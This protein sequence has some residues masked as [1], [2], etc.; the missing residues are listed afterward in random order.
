MGS[1]LFHREDN[2]A[3]DNSIDDIAARPGVFGGV[4]INIAWSQIEPSPGRFTTDVI[5]RALDTVRSYNRAHPTA[6]LGV[7]LR[8][9]PGRNAPA[10]VNA[11]GGPPIGVRRTIPGQPT[12][13]LSI[14]RFWT[15]AYRSAYASMQ[16]DLARKYD[17]DPLVREVSN[18]ACATMSDEPFVL[19]ID[20]YS[21]ANLHRAGFSDAAYR[22]CL[23]T[24]VSDFSGWRATNIHFT[25]NPFH[26][27]DTRP[28]RLD[29]DFA[30]QVMRDFRR[31]LGSR[32]VIANHALGA[33]GDRPWLTPL[34]DAMKGFEAPKEFQTDAPM[35]RGFDWDAAVSYGV[36]L[37][38]TAVEL[39]QGTR[40]RGFETVP[41]RSL[42][43]WSAELKR[44]ARPPESPS[45]HDRHAPGAGS[46]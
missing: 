23:R 6:P 37:G 28:A 7:D 24:S 45:S 3:P 27:T 30:V 19:P 36:S 2:V 14:G 9:W 18:T 8:I 5:D 21:V 15:P 13:N 33:P 41:E 20:P 1:I 29:T 11:L 25:F 44:N 43:Q 39:W 31:S 22:E 4:V 16:R 32:A 38:A 40:I 12:A 35:Q 10:W 42:S 46:T 26:P 34:F 17:S